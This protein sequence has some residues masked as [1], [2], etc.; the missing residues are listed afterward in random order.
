MSHLFAL[1]DQAATENVEHIRVHVLLDGRD[2]RDFSALEYVDALESKLDRL[3]GSGRNDYR[4]AS[5]GGRMTTTMDRYGANWAIVEEGWKAHVL[6]CARPFPSA[7]K[8]IATFR[9]E[10]PGISDQFLPAFTVVHGDRPVGSIEDGDA[11]VVFNFR[12]DRAIEFSR[13]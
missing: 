5:G 1:L 4:V 6:G 12:G 10:S 7:T 8:A 13:P 11:V 2:V 3:N 9:E